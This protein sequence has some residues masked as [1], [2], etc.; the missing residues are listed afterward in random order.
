MTDCEAQIVLESC[1]SSF[2]C[3]DILLCGLVVCAFVD[4][5]DEERMVS[6]SSVSHSHMKYIILIVLLVSYIVCELRKCKMMNK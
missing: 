5:E 6:I 2:P 3:Y 4:V 1:Y